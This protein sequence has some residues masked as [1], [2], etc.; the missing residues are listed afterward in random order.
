MNG[1]LICYVNTIR[2]RGFYLMAQKTKDNLE[3]KLTIVNLLIPILTAVGAFVGIVLGF[4]VSVKLNDERFNTLKETIDEIKV[5]VNEIEDLA[6]ENEFK[7]YGEKIESLEEDIESINQK[8]TDL[9]VDLAVKIKFVDDFTLEKEIIDKGHRLMAPRWSETD[10]IAIDLTT[11]KS[12]TAKELT[13]KK[14]LYPYTED[15]Q[16]IYF[17]GQFNENNQW[18]G[19][20]ILNIYEN[21]NLVSIMDANYNNGSIVDYKQ[22]FIDGN[23][24]IV[25]D[26]KNEGN[27]NS[28]VTFRYSKTQDLEKKFTLETV[29]ATD[30]INVEDFFYEVDT[31][32]V[33]YYYGNTSN[34]KYNDSTEEAYLVKYAEDGTVTVL[35]QGQFANGKFDDNTNNA[36][37]IVRN[38]KTNYMY[39]KGKFDNGSPVNNEGSY[40]KTNLSIEEIKELI[41]DK[42]YQCELKWFGS[43]N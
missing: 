22:V 17:Y 33:S 26:R 3:K 24:W 29:E 36:W 41:K 28:G 13:E 34:G 6:I 9:T 11:N 5:S 12:Y 37:Y 21:N 19:A 10:I 8:I 42:N 14:I 32:L 40:G 4:I 38:D 2:K 20:C 23:N 31:K 27:Y 16:E 7:H 43:L 39:Y 18:H 1:T 25:S 15:G 30:V 35:Y